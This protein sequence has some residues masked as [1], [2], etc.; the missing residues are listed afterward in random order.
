V[1][2]YVPYERNLSSDCVDESEVSDHSSDLVVA[3]QNGQAHQDEESSESF[4]NDLIDDQAEEVNAEESEGDEGKP[5]ADD[6]SDNEYNS[7]ADALG[8]L[9][10]SSC[11]QGNADDSSYSCSTQS[12][13]DHILLTN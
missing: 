6:F 4:H 7:E 8:G 5:F 13:S 3:D 2:E 10:S 11:L 9:S 1:N 12:T